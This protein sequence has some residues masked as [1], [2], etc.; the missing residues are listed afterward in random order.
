MPP[1]QG[2]EAD[3][4]FLPG[5]HGALDEGRGA[6]GTGGAPGHQVPEGVPAIRPSRRRRLTLRQISCRE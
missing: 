5:G 1:V 3:P 6:G 4:P 2:A